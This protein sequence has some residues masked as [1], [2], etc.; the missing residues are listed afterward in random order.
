MS[1]RQPKLQ[2]YFEKGVKAMGAQDYEGAAA[3][4]AAVVE[5]DPTDRESLTLYEKARMLEAQ[6]GLNLFKRLLYQIVG[7]FLYSLQMNKAASHYLGVL[8]MD[9]PHDARLA[10]MYGKTLMAM[11]QPALAS[12]AYRRA[13]K[14]LPNNKGILKGA[15]PAFEAIDDRPS[16]IEV[17]HQLSRLEPTKGEWGLKVK[18][19]SATHYGETGGITN[20]KHARAEEEKRAAVQQ[21]IEGKEDRI[22]ELLSEYKS[23]PEEKKTLLP[24][25]GRLLMQIERYDQALAIWTRVLETAKADAEAEADEGEEALADEADSSHRP[26][27]SG[28]LSEEAKHSIAACHERKGQLDKA[29]EG[30]L[31]LF[32][33]YPTDARYCDCVYQ[34]R[35]K[36]V[37]MEIAENPTDTALVQRRAELERE[38]LERKVDIYRELVEKRPGDP[39]ILMTYGSALHQKGDIDEAIPVYQ[40]ASQNPA[41]AYPALRHLGWLFI[42]KGQIPLAVD[43]FKRALEKAPPARTPT[44]DMKDIWYG[45]GECYFRQGDRAN[46]REWW[47]NIYESDIEFRDIKERYESL[48]V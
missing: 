11:G 8:S 22:K 23:S 20:L 45:L 27:L 9:R 46:A 12:L 7:G 31:S 3:W 18:N 16:A 6:K 47:K 5:I 36:R 10:G 48:M 2:S 13:L 35:L 43:T 33:E 28:R 29:E 19:L 15:G 37:D 26:A 32:E 38:H 42:E 41:R 14:F 44:S 4:F 1:E 25:I 30:Y 24:E 21:T 34:V 40:K 39:D 17:Y